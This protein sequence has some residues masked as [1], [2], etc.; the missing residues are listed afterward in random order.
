M[1][2]DAV[3]YASISVLGLRLLTTI[4]LV[5]AVLVMPVRGQPEFFYS[6]EMLKSLENGGLLAALFLAP[7]Q[8]KAGPVYVL[9]YQPGIA[10]AVIL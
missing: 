2:K 10:L 5:V 8:E 9:H 4:F 7:A 6:E 3:N 1:N